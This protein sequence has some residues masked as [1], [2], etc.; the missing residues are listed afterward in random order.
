[1]CI[2]FCLIPLVQA[3]LEGC[4]TYPLSDTSLLCTDNVLESDAQADCDTNGCDDLD[5]YFSP[6]IS[7]DTIDECEEVLCSVSCDYTSYLLCEYEGGVEVTDDMYEQW[8]TPG[9]CRTGDFCS[10]VDFRNDCVSR[11]EQ[12]GLEESSMSYTINVDAA[13]CSVDICGYEVE[14]STITG[15]VQNESGE[16]VEFTIMLN[17]GS[18]VTDTGYFEFNDVLPNTYTLTITTEEYSTYRDTITVLDGE[19]LELEYVVVRSLG[20][21]TVSGL[22]T[23]ID[24]EP[25]SQVA[26]TLEGNDT[27]QVST[28]TD[29]FFEFT[30][31]NTGEHV[32]TLSKSYHTVLEY[33]LSLDSDFYDTFILEEIE[34]QGVKGVTY[35]DTMGDLSVLD[36]VFGA[37]IYVNDIFKESSEYPDGT[38]E[39][40]L[41]P[42]A[43]NISAIFED[44]SVDDLTLNVDEG[45][46]ELDYDII[47]S[48]YIGEC[49]YGQPNATKP[50]EVFESSVERGMEAVFLSWEKPCPEVDGYN[51]YKDG[52]KLG[53]ISP[54]IG[55]YIDYDV[56]WE[57]SYTYALEAIYTDGPADDAGA[58]QTR[59]STEQ[60]SITVLTG[61][62]E[63]DNIQES[64]FFC[65]I[66]DSTTDDNERK[67]IYACDDENYVVLS[68][69]CSELDTDST[70]YYCT[71]IGETN[72]ICKDAGM[73]NVDS[74]LA[75]PFGLYYEESTCYGDYDN[76]TG[77]LNFC[78]YDYS[79]TIVDDC[80]DCNEV[81]TCFDYRSQDSCEI[82]NCLGQGCL[83]VNQSDNTYYDS[84]VL[85]PTTEEFGTGYCAPQDYVEDDQCYLCGPDSQL[86]EN[87]YCTPDVCDQLGSCFSDTNN[88]VCNDCGDSPSQ[89]ANC[90]EY[91][92]E[93]ECIGGVPVSSI[94][95][96]I[97][98]SN[99]KCSWG[100]CY[101]YAANETHG[102]CYKDGNYDSY[103]D[104]DE[105]SAG[106][107]ET[108][109]IDNEGPITEIN[110]G[111]FAVVSNSFPSIN[112]SS[113][114]DIS[115]VT[116]L[117]YCLTSSQSSGCTEDNFDY[118]E[119]SGIINSESAE[120]NLVNSTYLQSVI[121][122]GDTYTLYYLA[123]DKYYNREDL[124]TTYVFVD[125]QNPDFVLNYYSDTDADISELT[126]YLTEPSEPAECDFILEQKLPE[127]DTQTVSFSRDEDKEHYFTSLTGVIY[128]LTASCTDDHGNINNVSD[129]IVFDLEQDISF[130][131]PEFG[132]AVH[133]TDIVF[134][135]ST[136]VGASC[137][138]YETNDGVAWT[139][140]AEF[141]TS[142]DENKN[143]STSSIPNFY[144][145]D[146][147]GFLK[148]VCVESYT[149]EVME[150]YF[151]FVV[152]F[153]APD[154][155]A[156]L[157]EGDREELPV[158]DEWELYWIES[159]NIDF[160]CS[161][162][163][164][165]CAET[166][167]C[168]GEGCESRSDE[169]YEVYSGTVTI[170]NTTRMCYYSTD[171]V[172][173]LVDVQC[174][175]IIV[176]GFG[177]N[178]VLPEL[179]YYGGEQYGVSSDPVFD[180]VIMSK[181]NTEACTYDFNPEFDFDSQP[182]YKKFDL[183]EDK[184]NYYLYEDFPGDVLA[185][186]DEDGGK[187]TLY[188]KCKDPLGE[189]GP[190]QKMNLE[191]DPSKPIILTTNVEPELVTDMRTVQLTVTTD[192]KTVCKFD[193]VTN[194]GYDYE[195]MR[196]SFEGY[197]DNI[198]NTTH[199]SE[200]SFDVDGAT[201]DFTLAVQCENGAGLVS[202]QE[203][204]DFSVDYAVVGYIESMSPTGI[205]DGKEVTL[206]VQTSK[207]ALCEVD[208]EDFTVSGNTVH[209]KYIGDLV[210]SNDPYHYIV[211]CLISENY[212]D[213]TIEFYVDQTPPSITST[214][215]GEESCGLHTVPLSVTVN[216]P[217]I[218]HYEYNLY[219]G[220]SPGSS[221]LREYLGLENA[222]DTILI[223]SGTLNLTAD[224][225][226]VTLVN[227][228]PY[229]IEV[230]AVDS[231]GNVGEYV[232]TD[233]FVAGDGSSE[234][235]AM[236]IFG[237]DIQVVTQ[238][239]QCMGSVI[240]LECSDDAG[241]DDILYGT[242]TSIADC[243]PT[244]DKQSGII[245]EQNQWLC[246]FASDTKGNNV[247]G[248]QK[249]EFEDVDGD[250]VA[251]QCDICTETSAGA[252]V[253]STG[254]A[255]QETS[256]TTDT[257]G[258]GLPDS[259]EKLSTA[260]GCEL[261]H[262]ALDTDMNGV[263]DTDEDFDSDGLNNL[264]EYQAGKDPCIDDTFTEP[265]VETE[266]LDIPSSSSS[267]PNDNLGAIIV[268]LLSLLMMG[269]SS[270]FLSY[271][272]TQM[273]QGRALFGSKPLYNKQVQSRQVSPQNKMANPKSMKPNV[274]QSKAQ[275]LTQKKVSVGDRLRSLEENFSK[276]TKKS[277]RSKL[278]S[279]FTAKKSVEHL[280]RTAHEDLPVHKK[281]AEVTKHFEANKPEIKK[282]VDTNLF[283][284]LENL[285]S[286]H[287]KNEVNA[288][289]A[290]EVFKKL[291]KLSK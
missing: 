133:E 35:L 30:D 194:D 122:A 261:D 139:K 201:A 180:W 108:C 244:Q 144:E 13:Y 185:A 195:N 186:Y 230:L 94:D 156:I 216:E 89:D 62:K 137:E 9:C 178:M 221:Q 202:N 112:L 291:R 46:T 257:D 262:E 44:Y 48:R 15:T 119:Y 96:D 63:C 206:E 125:T 258:D 115:P 252:Q 273:P 138:L 19:T 147:A 32:L 67:L 184:T 73:C 97:F 131:Y 237:P 253:D 141:Y 34:F 246:Y 95:M 173:N 22:I 135:I 10:L 127:G 224:I 47:L 134:Q 51:L 168:F 203:T 278:F 80:I 211:S 66:D 70:D 254:C 92:S 69:D 232:Y 145:G 152:D 241:C 7:C 242:S 5:L 174:G 78:Y 238:A 54:Y 37:K 117:Y 111:S 2:L 191:Y 181:L 272:Y 136:A 23:D 42:G 31:V 240:S 3:E 60:I 285:S 41:E 88:S 121:E 99:D 151:D 109:K 197:D 116:G 154:T 114:D 160:E 236:D 26:V 143:H 215:D 102:E 25:L 6:G 275:P 169:K 193:D 212:D 176:E 167:Y 210:E 49:S 223:S 187:K 110:T 61:D 175:E 17:D 165:D 199:V 159:V 265:V 279:S 231:A 283:D 255:R 269:G 266:V 288:K 170:T 163:G 81:Q 161:A 104:C 218:S 171:T 71:I 260:P 38:F 196:Y 198:L 280:M 64:Q 249:I 282:Q 157:T 166:F 130:V 105:F 188:V 243:D 205:I 86:F 50:V 183:Y 155:Q 228:T 208:G 179:Y 234:D 39:I 16:D 118:Y 11:T 129:T 90:Y 124:Q 277:S 263:S 84:P 58:P 65:G 132:G 239:Q 93:L 233:G 101:W 267:S 56:E 222:T 150:D 72:A 289:D 146:Y 21:H 271:F 281:V 20:E 290:N 204:I 43:Y 53:V 140:L 79:D 27:V 126:V 57:T 148:A 4:Y 274:S 286:A 235:C 82:D 162:E 76:E 8:C 247:T 270:G 87:M 226:G 100:T 220:N 219:Q 284:K 189:V 120:I 245:V 250:G 74:M 33:D 14:T 207:N 103:N 24:G 52:V 158:G 149:D 128:N 12:Q 213:D 77:Y 217:N 227:G 153:T 107:Y 85:Y 28:D 172:E 91:T 75:T 177:I 106:E 268:L 259:W 113:V 190:A 1:M 248:N 164:F 123:E 200:Y 264:E 59:I 83:W 45:I 142:D 251:D 225:E 214:N 18:E 182:E 36:P 209:T 229:Y 276:R 287:K 40:Y 192:D 29:G 98:N 55:T 256:D 68:N